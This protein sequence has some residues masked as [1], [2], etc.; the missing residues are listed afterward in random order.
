MRS[1]LVFLFAGENH[2]QDRTFSFIWLSR[3]FLGAGFCFGL[4]FSFVRSS[5]ISEKKKLPHDDFLQQEEAEDSG[6]ESLGFPH[7]RELRP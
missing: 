7:V 1:R 5:Q 4:L 6:C 3:G 2:R